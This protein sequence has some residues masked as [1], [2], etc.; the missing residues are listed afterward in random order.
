MRALQQQLPLNLLL[1]ALRAASGMD[2]HHDGRIAP[3][4]PFRSVLLRQPA[5]LYSAL[6]GSESPWQQAEMLGERKVLP[7]WCESCRTDTVLVLVFSTPEQTSYWDRCR[8]VLHLA[9]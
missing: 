9:A 2:A 7:S 8:N 1:A 3:L 5:H 4:G 6:T